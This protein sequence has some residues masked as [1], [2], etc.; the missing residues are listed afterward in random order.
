MQSAV[1]HVPAFDRAEA[2]ETAHAVHAGRLVH[3]EHYR[4]PEAAARVCGHLNRLTTDRRERRVFAVVIQPTTTQDGVIPVAWKV[5]QIGDVAAVI[6]LFASIWL[7]GFASL[8][9]RFA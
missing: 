5:D 3:A 6:A 4:C 9:E 1:Y 7:V 8:W 2:I